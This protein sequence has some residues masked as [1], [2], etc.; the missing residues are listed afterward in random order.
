[1]REVDKPSLSSCAI[2]SRKLFVW[3]LSSDCSSEKV[4]AGKFPPPP[5]R[6]ELH[7]RVSNAQ[8]QVERSSSRRRRRQTASFRKDKSGVLRIVE[9]I[10]STSHEWSV[11]VS[12]YLSILTRACKPMAAREPE[13]LLEPNAAMP[14]E[15]AA[16]FLFIPSL[17]VNHLTVASMLRGTAFYVVVGTRYT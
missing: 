14:G 16:K 10:R 7:R 6:P 3:E 11:R 1:M 8:I 4:K 15:R 5:C 17:D 2:Y 9:Q 12:L 13:L